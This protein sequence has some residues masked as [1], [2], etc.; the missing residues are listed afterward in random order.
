MKIGE[1]IKKLRIAK[2]MTQSELVGSEITR[3]MLSRIENGSANPSLETVRYIAERLNVSPSFLLADEED[4]LIYLKHREISQIKQAFMTEDFRICRD[5]CLNSKS[6]EDDEIQ[7]ILSEC[8][9]YV[10]AEEFNGGNLKGACS[11][12]DE[13]LESCGRTLYRT[14]L[15]VATVG[16]YFRYMRRFSA[17]LS[18]N[19]IDEGEVNIY[20]ALT[21]EFCRY[22]YALE[23][24]DRKEPIGAIESIARKETPYA[25]HLEAKLWMQEGQYGQAYECLHKILLNDFPVAEPMLYFVFCD[26]EI[27]CREIQDFKGAYEYSI[28]KVELF[29]KLLT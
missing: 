17:T 11:Y 6:T 20:P 28:D 7:M 18:S 29:Q 21:E 3:N 5:M 26:L 1:K 12:L 10:A 2:L 4:E 22:A 9:L 24:L 16:I 15:I 27:C 19:V 23:Q 14:D 8:N 13:A 25:L